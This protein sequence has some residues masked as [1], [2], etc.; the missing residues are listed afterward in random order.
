MRPTFLL[1]HCYY[2]MV[3]LSNFCDHCAAT[4]PV[5]LWS[6]LGVNMKFPRGRVLRLPTKKNPRGNFDPDRL[7]FFAVVAFLSVFA[8]IF[9]VELYY[10]EGQAGASNNVEYEYQTN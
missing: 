7:S 4:L 8:V 5:A 6:R 2:Y 1:L 9:L 3:I 10:N